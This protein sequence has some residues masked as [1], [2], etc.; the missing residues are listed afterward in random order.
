[1]KEDEIAGVAAGYLRK[2]HWDVY[3]EV[4]PYPGGARADIVGIQ[5]DEVLILEA[6]RDVTFRLLAQ[7]LAWDGMAHQLVVATLMPLRIADH[8]VVLDALGI[9]WI[10]VTPPAPNGPAFA[11]VQVRPKSRQPK[12]AHA[13]RSRVLEEQKAHAPGN[14]GGSYFTERDRAHKAIADFVEGYSPGAHGA[15][16][17]FVL[18]HLDIKPTPELVSDL[19]RGKVDRVQAKR[20][21]RS[22]FLWPTEPVL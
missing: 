3:P 13:M 21:G 17:K 8:I 1:M 2:C 6:K 11:S 5:G 10:V 18:R 22:W 15:E 14:A 7:T 4:T 16:L 12:L 19:R 9:G 20:S